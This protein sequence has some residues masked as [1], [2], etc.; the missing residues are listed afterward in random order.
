M[1]RSVYVSYSQVCVFNSD[2]SDPYNDWSPDHSRQGF[3][4]RPGS[5]SFATS[6]NCGSVNL[7]VKL[8]NKFE[9][10]DAITIIRVPFEVYSCGNVECGSIMSGFIFSI[11][12][13]LYSLYFFEL[14]NRSGIGLTFVR[15]ISDPMIIRFPSNMI[16][17]KNLIMNAN[18][19]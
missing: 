19:A 8:V 13:G 18:S 5:V 15:G 12:P 4:W 2:I 1:E 11:T 7:S 16:V 14:P 10:P 9:F 3:S 17:P 6:F